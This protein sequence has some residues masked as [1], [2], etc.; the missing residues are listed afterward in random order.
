MKTFIQRHPVLAFY[1][2]VF[3]ISWGGILM[4]IGGLGGIPATSEQVEK[5][6]PFVML[7]LFAGPSVASILLTSIVYGKAGWRQLLSRLLRWRVGIRWYAVAL[8]TAPILYLAVPLTLSLLSPDFLPSIFTTDDKASL[9]LFGIAWGLIGGGFLEELGWTG[10]AVPELRQRYSLLATAL[11]V[12]VLWGAWHLLVVFWLGGNTLGGVPLA[13]FL[14]VRGVD[15]LV[16]SLVAY[17]VL[18]VW[19]Y[20]HTD[21]SLLIAMLMHAA[22]SASMLI[23]QPAAISGT[24]FLTYC[25]VL[26]AVIWVAVAVVTATTHWHRTRQPLHQELTMANH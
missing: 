20:D 12:G 3:V 22:L 10:F 7:A 23:L 17:R 2:V 16:G 21:G 1:I 9:L 26:S 14:P 11:I 5:L 13:L 15:L 4:S 19:V 6:L 24:R 18:M 8:L 25:L